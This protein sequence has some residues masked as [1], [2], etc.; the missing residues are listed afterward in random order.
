VNVCR[1][2]TITLATVGVTLTPTAPVIVSA[3]FALF[4]ASARL[5]AV[6]VTL[7]GEGAAAGAMY[8]AVAVPP[9][10]LPAVKVLAAIVPAAGLPP[11]TPFTLHATP[12]AAPAVA[13]IVA[14]NTCAPFICTLAV[15]G[16]R[17][18]FTSSVIFSEADA[19]VCGA[20]TL[21]AEIVTAPPATI[22][23][24]AAYVAASP[25]APLAAIVPTLAF[26]PA[27]PS[28]PH[29]TAVF[30]VPVTVA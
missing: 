2:L 30:E 22:T 27:M 28:T 29:A 20:A 12:D 6:T 15:A 9:A 1:W 25:A 4:V 23:D 7:A 19:I 24:G 17:L 3:A 14:V 10:P 21:T 18:T 16:A 26:P 8:T 11:V 5:V 13:V